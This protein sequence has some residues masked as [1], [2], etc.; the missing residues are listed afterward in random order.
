M[1]MMMMI[2]II[3]IIIIILSKIQTHDSTGG[4]VKRDLSSWFLL[5]F[6][7][8]LKEHETHKETDFI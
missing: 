6:F 1:M 5:L 3:I 4:Q 8:K 7:W 2:I